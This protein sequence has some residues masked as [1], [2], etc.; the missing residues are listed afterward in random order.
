MNDMNEDKALPV[1][2]GDTLLRCIER[3][4]E[5]PDTD[6]FV[7]AP[8]NPARFDYHPGQFILV[9]VEIEGEKHQRAY[10]L[11]SSP[12]RPSSLAITVKRVDGGLVSIWL[13]DHLHKGNTVDASLPMGQ[14][15]LREDALPKEVVLL[16]AGCGI[17]PMMSMSRWLLDTGHDRK[18]QFIHSARDLVNVIFREELQDIAQKHP[19]FMLELVLERD[20][21]SKEN[22]APRQLTKECLAKLVPDTSAVQAYLCGPQ[23][24]MTCVENWLLEIGLPRDCLF[25]E[26]FTAVN[27][28]TSCLEGETWKLTAPT[29]GKSV[30]IGQGQSLLDAME[31]GQLPII[32]ACRSGVCGSCKCKVTSGNVISTSEATLTPEQIKDGYVLACSSTATG[33]LSVEL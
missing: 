11:S 27:G 28:P 4:K 21:G 24:Y 23:A 29:F 15:Y 8:E 7:L 32:G 6:T 22:A 19:N 20:D 14:F 10:S 17:T 25:K 3:R 13:H 1:W 5:T 33:D 16:S 2:G 31:K 30:E 12:S 26:S 18:I 9:G